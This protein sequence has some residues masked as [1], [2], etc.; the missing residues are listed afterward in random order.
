[1][2]LKSALRASF[3]PVYRWVSDVSFVQDQAHRSVFSSRFRHWRNRNPC[4]EFPTRTGYFRHLFE[5]QGLDA[6]IDYLEFGVWE[7][8]SIRWWVEANRHPESTF[9]GFD[10]FMGLPTNWEGMPRGSFS[11]HGQIPEIPDPRCRFIEGLFHETLPPWLAGRNL[12]RR[13]VV[14]LDAD[15]YGST[16][17]VLLQLMPLLKSGDILLFDELHSYMHEFRALDD[18]LAAYPMELRALAR[19]CGWTQVALQVA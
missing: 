17:L 14:H 19:A 13:L 12:T 6:A 16:L 18:A 1:M 15:L 11:T 9:T 2:N 8:D 10:S 4:P 7:G 3:R 5:S